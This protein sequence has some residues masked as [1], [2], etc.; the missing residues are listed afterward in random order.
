M[1]QVV[2]RFAP[3]PSGF[4]HLGNLFCSLIAWLA[5]KS[6][7]GILVFRNED[8]DLE[9][10]RP[11]FALQAQRDLERLGLS[12][13]E[14]GNL[15]GPH[16]P[17][18]Q[19]QRF[20]FYASQLEKLEWLGLVYPC[21]CTRAQ[22]HAASAPHGDDG[23]LLYS[24]ACR[25]LTPEEI[26]ERRKTRSPA[27]RLRVPAETIS[28]TDGHYGPQSQFLPTGCGDF[29]LRRSDGIYAY[30][31]AVVADDGAM[32]VTQVVRGRDLLSSTPR[33][34][35]LY[36]LLGYPVPQFAHTPLLLSSD[37]RRLAKRDGDMSLSGLIA[38]GFSP[39]D[40]VGGLA[41]LAGLVPEPCPLLPEELVPL[42]SWDKLPKEDIL[43]PPR[44]F[45]N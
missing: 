9:R 23:E 28:F 1:G 6:Q 12:W 16:G 15:G 3:S 36:R 4:L 33:Q 14:G 27:L 10:S 45:Q 8:L 25:N 7:G 40:V 24:G 5:A 17:Y 30:Q 2:G 32:G 26:K 20:D 19:S 31:L 39:R 44:L 35:L 42:F 13:E 29:I 21:F 38:K 41:Y 34:I 37:G 22:L 11:A 43:L 18:N